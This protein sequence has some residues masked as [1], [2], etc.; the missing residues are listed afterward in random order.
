MFKTSISI[1]YSV[2]EGQSIY[3]NAHEESRCNSE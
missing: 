3:F 2:G 1:T